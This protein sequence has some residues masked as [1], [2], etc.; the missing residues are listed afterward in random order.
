METTY[1]LYAGPLHVH[2]YNK[3]QTFLALV[4][5]LAAFLAKSKYIKTEFLHL[6][7]KLTSSTPNIYVYFF[8]VITQHIFALFGKFPGR[9]A[10]HDWYW[11]CVVC[12]PSST[13]TWNKLAKFS[14]HSKSNGQLLFPGIYFL[15]PAFFY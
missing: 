5:N 10:I 9:K 4:R 14:G 12:V 7:N 1:I 2:R 6:L 13:T 8:S 15:S 3:M 11:Q